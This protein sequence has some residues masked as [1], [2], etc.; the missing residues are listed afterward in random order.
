MT[1]QTLGDALDEGMRDRADSVES[2]ARVLEVTA[3]ELL[4]WLADERVPDPEASRSVCR[5]LAI[6]ERRYR[7]LCLRSQMH[8]VQTVIRYGPAESARAS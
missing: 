5:Y 6:D 3:D 1:L 2:A 8:H 7:G 4:A